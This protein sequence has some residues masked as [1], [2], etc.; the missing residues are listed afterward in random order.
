MTCVEGDGIDADADNGVESD[1]GRE[2]VLATFLGSLSDL[3][4]SSALPL[5]FARSGESLRSNPFSPSPPGIS[6]SRIFRFL[7]R[8]SFVSFI[9]PM[10]A[11]CQETA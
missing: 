11:F 4:L 8:F 10:A 1:V 5:V 2:G 7:P 6:S 3:S 9:A